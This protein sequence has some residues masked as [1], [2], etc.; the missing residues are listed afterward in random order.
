MR[1]LDDVINSMDTI[2]SRLQE[3]VKDREA[4]YAAVHGVAQSWTQLSD[5]TALIQQYCHQYSNL[6]TSKIKNYKNWNKIYWVCYKLPVPQSFMKNNFIFVSFV[7]LKFQGAFGWVWLVL[8]L[9]WC[10]I[11]GLL[12]DRIRKTKERGKG[13]NGKHCI[14]SEQEEFWMN[15]WK[16][17]FMWLWGINW[18]WVDFRKDLQVPLLKF[19]K[20]LL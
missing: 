12:R 20:K 2:L 14:D 19:F 6:Q 10:R 13:T 8:G 3:V 11:R 15:K 16:E 1:W 18:S 17:E 5:W 7:H 9:S 4:W